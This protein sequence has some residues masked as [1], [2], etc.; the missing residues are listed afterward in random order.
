MRH[1]SPGKEEE[2]K[3]EEKAEKEDKEEKDEKDLGLFHELHL[4]T[5]ETMDD[6][7]G[8]FHILGNI[9]H[10]SVF[11]KKKGDGIHPFPKTNILR[12]PL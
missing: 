5:L 9:F 11:F 12:K 8:N 3:E 10:F 7:V 2:E 4:N 1:A 6:K